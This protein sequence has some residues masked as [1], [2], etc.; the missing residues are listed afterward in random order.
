MSYLKRFLFAFAS[1][2]LLSAVPVMAQV[3]TADITGR[4][5][6]Q[7]GAA[8]AGAT[9]TARNAGTGQERSA[10]SDQQGNYTIAELL[11]GTYDITVEAANFSKA[12]VKGREVNVGATVTLNFDL[13][14]GQITEV[15]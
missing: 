6:D 14:P 4:V 15:V 5:L 8:V 3:T 7:N 13:K 11:P 9:V 12:V 2:V 10:Q 1:A